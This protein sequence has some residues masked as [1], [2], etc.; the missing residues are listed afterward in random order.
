MFFMAYSPQST[1]AV[2]TNYCSD[3]APL[4]REKA[5]GRYAAGLVPQLPAR[6]PVPLLCLP[7]SEVTP[8][9]WLTLLHA[10]MK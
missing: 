3:D 2:G 8:G 5:G 7:H 10:G 1:V 9:T 6:G 4:D